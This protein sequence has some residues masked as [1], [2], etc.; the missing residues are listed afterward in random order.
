MMAALPRIDLSAEAKRMIA[1]AK[2]RVS[3]ASSVKRGN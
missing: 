2:A 3:S 1:D